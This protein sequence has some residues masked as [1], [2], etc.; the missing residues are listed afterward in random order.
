MKFLGRTAQVVACGLMVW[1]A[2]VPSMRAEQGSAKVEAI[3]A[4]TATYSADGQTFSPLQKG[5]VLQQG[6]TVKTDSM[7]IVDLYLGKNG[8]MVR[9]TPATTLVLTAMTFDA[10]AGETVVNTELGLSTGR[11][12]GIVR[13]MSASSRYEVKTPVG[14]CGIRGTKY[15][16]SATGRVIVEEGVVD[17]LFSPPGAASPTRFEVR[18]G[19]MFDPTLNSGRGGV[20][21]T[22][23][24]IREL[25][26]DEYRQM[27]GGVPSEE[28]AQIWV[29]SPSWLVP[30]RPVDPSGAGGVS[31]PWE[32]PP[33]S[34]PGSQPTTEVSPGG[35]GSN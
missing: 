5:T 8:P 1:A 17:V 20:V 12:Q 28:R 25:Q 13:K 19:Y 2:L 22:P 21:P 29:P 6:A 16:V 4:G 30:E 24:N 7:G 26:R 34:N 15:E 9:L 27:G 23:V 18:A 10:G 11:I 3:R 33:V 32:L 14:T 31:K 35:G